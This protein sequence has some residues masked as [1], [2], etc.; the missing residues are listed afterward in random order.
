MFKDKRK[1]WKLCRE[2]ETIKTCHSNL[3]IKRSKKN[4]EIKNAMVTFNIWDTVE[5]RLMN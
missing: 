4:Q 3:E 5:N 2:L 1:P